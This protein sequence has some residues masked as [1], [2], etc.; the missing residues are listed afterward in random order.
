MIDRSHYAVTAVSRPEHLAEAQA[1]I[2]AAIEA[3]LQAGGSITRL[4]NK[5]SP[6]EHLSW[7]EEA[8]RTK[9]AGLS[10]VSIRGHLVLRDQPKPKQE[11][12]LAA[13]QRTIKTAIQ[14]RS[15]INAERR[16]KLAPQVRI[17]ADCKWTTNQIASLLEV[18]P[19]TVRRIAREHE[20]ELNTDRGAMPARAGGRT[21]RNEKI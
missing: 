3:Y 8:K 2:D 15:R 13:R 20:I 1:E 17:L 16:D 10:F 6:I 19:G 18:A 5:G 7:R 12:A 11:K 21:M 9:A 14:T 4:D